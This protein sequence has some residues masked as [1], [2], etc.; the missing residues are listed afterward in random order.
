MPNWV[1]NFLRITGDYEELL[2]FRD[3]Q[4][5]PYLNLD[6]KDI[7]GEEVELEFHSGNFPAT[8]WVKAVGKK[9]PS[10]KFE[11][12]WCDGS[13]C[14]CGF[15]DMDQGDVAEEGNFEFGCFCGIVNL[16]KEHTDQHTMAWNSICDDD[17]ANC[18]C[19][20]DKEECSDSCDCVEPASVMAL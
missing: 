10:L 6:E 20:E 18:F 13:T 7:D 5:C 19:K 3:N 14:S 9:W 16:M 11:H 8:E 15:L 2:E 17:I 4:K 1:D 12:S